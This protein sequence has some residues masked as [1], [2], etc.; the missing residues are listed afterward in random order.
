M[1]H[2]HRELAPIT[3]AAWEAIEHDARA[4]LTTYLASRKVVDFAGPHGWAHS[5]TDLGRITPVPGPSE[6]VT[7]QRRIDPDQPAVFWRG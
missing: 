4:R 6:G 7:A 5:A 3:D 1:D 2:L